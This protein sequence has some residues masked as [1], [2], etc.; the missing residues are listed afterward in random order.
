MTQQQQPQQAGDAREADNM[1]EKPDLGRTPDALGE[2]LS[3]SGMGSDTRAGSLQGGAATGSEI[4]PD[5]DRINE[6]LATEGMRSAAPRE[7]A[8][9]NARSINNTGA[10]EPADGRPGGGD[11]AD[12][13]TG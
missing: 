6:S 9:G 13:A 7:P 1:G 8:G 5:Q 3:G 2:A 10:D 4:D 12:A 11:E